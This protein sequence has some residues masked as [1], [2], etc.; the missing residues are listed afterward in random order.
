MAVLIPTIN[1]CLGRMT[2]G[3]RRFGHQLEDDYCCWYDVP[4][5]PKHFHPDFVVFHPWRGLLVLEV[6]DWKLDTIRSI[7]KKEVKLVTNQGLKRVVNPLLQARSYAFA[8][9]NLL[10][11]D[12]QLMFPPTAHR[13][14]KLIFPYGYGV[15]FSNITRRQFDQTDLGLVIEPHL[16]ICKDEMTDSTDAE[17]FQTRLWEMLPFVPNKPISLPQI[18]RI[19]W[20]LFP[21]IRIA[22]SQGDLFQNDGAGNQLDSAGGPAVTDV[23]RVMDFQQEQLARSLGE[24]HRVIHGVAG[25]GKTLILGYRCEHLA[26]VSTKPIL[27]LCYN[28]TLARSLEQLML[29]KH[30]EE[31]VTVCNF[32]RWCSDQLKAFHVELPQQSNRYFDELVERLIAAADQGMI[33]TGQYAAVLIDE[34][35][36][37]RPEWLKLVV[38]MVDPQT[39]SLLVLYDDAQSIYDR[40]LNAKFTFSSV[41]IKARGRTT[42]LKL[43]YRNT[44]EV[45]AL[46]TSF[47]GDFLESN[48]SGED[49][50]PTL[51]PMAA[52][53]AGPKP[54][55]VTLPTLAQE[56]DYLAAQLTEA[57]A[58]GVT[59]REMAVIYRTKFVATALTKSLKAANIPVELM[60][61][62][63]SGRNNFGANDSVKLLTMHSSK[64]L[65]FPVVGIAGIGYMPFKACNAT[66][67]ARLLCVAMTRTTNQLILTCSKESAFTR[68]LVDA[69]ALTDQLT[70]EL[71]GS[72]GLVLT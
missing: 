35:H 49:Q 70:D 42:I 34:G 66:D 37:F 15:V 1:S 23:L 21:E 50:I 54:L 44:R 3:E 64:G 69:R 10:E 38:Q 46:A 71:T 11:Q 12:P 55:L 51:A 25:S 32:H 24:G 14:G 62:I 31:K 57:H 30:L 17:T 52:G 20:H 6:K 45:L 58:S 26:K 19:R 72:R 18:N 56:A 39:N 27:V 68:R 67:E 9:K 16:V 47:A 28:K 40:Q 22:S 59:W 13:A 53:R 7:S 4:V 29:S 43:N 61:D 33:P 60:T 2:A 41:G 5:G 8:V 65:E 48:E 63:K 36:D